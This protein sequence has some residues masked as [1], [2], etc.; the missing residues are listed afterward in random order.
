MFTH[1]LKGEEEGRKTKAME[2]SHICLRTVPSCR[3]RLMAV[4]LHAE[5]SIRASDT[6]TGFWR[7]GRRFLPPYEGLCSLWMCRWGE[8]PVSPSTISPLRSCPFTAREC[9]CR[10][11]W[12]ARRST[13]GWFGINLANSDKRLWIWRNELAVSPTVHDSGC[14]TL[15]LPA[16]RTLTFKTAQLFCFAWVEVNV[17]GGRNSCDDCV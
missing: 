15:L 17:V 10:Q 6:Y 16:V 13:P 8:T 1:S 14:R 3:G 5:M 4:E 9:V 7:V 2:L 11:P 12:W